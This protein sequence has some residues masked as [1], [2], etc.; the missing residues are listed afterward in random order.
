MEGSMSRFEDTV[1]CSGCG[2]EITW[3]PYII[4]DQEFC[5]QNCAYGFS[6]D[7]GAMM[8]WEDEYRDAPNYYPGI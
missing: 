5:C 6:C 4:D 8:D 3:I 1:W 2:I 7:C